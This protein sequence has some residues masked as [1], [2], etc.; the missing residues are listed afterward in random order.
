MIVKNPVLSLAFG[1]LTLA[2]AQ[3]LAAEPI[4]I[5]QR[6]A[7]KVQGYLG[8]GFTYQPKDA[9][10]GR[11]VVYNIVKG[12]PADLAGLKEDDLISRIDGLPIFI[13]D[14]NR[15]P[16]HPFKWLKPGD[17][18]K[19]VVERGKETFP[20]TVKVVP[21]PYPMG[22]TEAAM[23]TMAR[24]NWGVQIFDSWASRGVV[25]EVERQPDGKLLARLPGAAADELE[26]LATALDGRLGQDVGFNLAPGQKKKIRLGL[27]PVKG[28][29]SLFDVA[30]GG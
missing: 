20:V 7:A 1:L 27:H 12:G 3:V 30:P 25:L 13:P 28:F 14:W 18:L 21:Q 6:P 4:P 15:N 2:L 10:E 26:A 16:L 24:H 22:D 23:K 29:P 8:L 9:K 19:L 17:E 5:E 11:I